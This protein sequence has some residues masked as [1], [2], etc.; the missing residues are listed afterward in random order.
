[1]RYN[2]IL[3]LLMFVGGRSFADM[4]QT[5]AIVY[6][7]LK[8]EYGKRII[9]GTMARI[10][11]NAD[12]A[13]YVYQWTGRW[14]A[15]N[16]FDYISFYGNWI[17]Y[18]DMS[19]VDNWWNQGGLV[20]CMW[21]WN[22]RANNG[23]DFTC[24]PGSAAKE[25]SFDCSKITN[26]NNT[27]YKQVI[28]DIDKVAESLKKMQQLDIPVIW[29]PLHEAAGNTNVYKGGTAWFW[30]GI[31]GAEPFKQLWHLMYD[32]LVNY[33]HL[34]NLIWVWTSQANDPEWY[35]GS[36]YVDI[37]A[38]DTYGASASTLYSEYQYLKNTYP[39]KLITLAECGTYGSAPCATVSQMQQAGCRWSWFMP[40]YDIDC[41]GGDYHRN[42]GKVWWQ[43]AMN[44]SVVIDRDEM[45][46]LRSKY[47]QETQVADVSLSTLDGGW[48]AS[49]S[50]NTITYTS[51]WGAKGWNNLYY[52]HAGESGA[53]LVIE[54]A[55]M[56]AERGTIEGEGIVN[57]GIRTNQKRYVVS[58][59]SQ[60]TNV[61]QV[62]IKSATKGVQYKLCRVYFTKW[63]NQSSAVESVPSS[64]RHTPTHLYDT[65]GRTVKPTY[66]GI[67]IHN[68]HKIIR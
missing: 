65:A 12:E 56:P 21:H 31:K 66:K 58:L 26:T 50:A 48:N 16:T 54:F 4:S 15:L 33:H 67:V 30:W 57:T 37:V 28:A 55:D 44:S 47:L 36:E 6:D 51:D 46:Q 52:A 11:W 59:V 10:D 61:G 29:R 25:T 2:L 22:M 45:L 24:T 43:D 39:D 3:Y 53:K 34:D 60:N 63:D 14:P 41:T 64:N 18:S 42:A 7:I 13:G 38:R 1:M 27:E 8:E 62:L 17:D 5:T 68:G 9:S 49:Y 35:P 40:W 23:T 19:V 20:S 32:R